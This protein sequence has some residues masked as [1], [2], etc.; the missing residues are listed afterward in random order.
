MSRHILMICTTGKSASYLRR[1]Y[2][3]LNDSDTSSILQAILHCTQNNP[4]RAAMIAIMS[5]PQAFA[6]AMKDEKFGTAHLFP[7][8]ETQTLLRWLQ[9]KAHEISQLRIIML[10]SQDRDSILTARTAIICLERL[11]P[12]YPSTK[13][14]DGGIIPLSIEVDNRQ[15]FLPTVANLFGEFDKLI[16]NKADDEEVIICSSGSFKAVAGFAMMYAQLHSLPC[17]YSYEASTKAYEVMSLPLGYAYAQM[18]EEINMLKAIHSNAPAD[19]TALPQWVKDSKNLAGA[20]LESYEQARV[21][22]YGTGEYLFNRLR[23]CKDGSAWADYLQRL[24]VK[25]WSQL[26]LGDQIPETVEHSRRHSKRLMELAASLF[27]CAGDRMQ[28][29]GFTRDDPATSGS[30]HCGNI[31]SRHRAYRAVLPGSGG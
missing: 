24:L 30:A 14:I 9:D 5:D 7:T 25:N 29:I 12:L 26:W 10:P 1:D 23:E 16:R 17:L 13:I 21:K 15:D 4:K 27:R 20:L 3:A 6:D 2:E 28:A 8:A 31:S 11:H 22:P 18:D 19:T